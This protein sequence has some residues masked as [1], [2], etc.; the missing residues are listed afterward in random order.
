MSDLK[1]CKNCVH[2]VQVDKD[3]GQCY[4]PSTLSA[5]YF[6]I[7]NVLCCDCCDKFEGIKRRVVSTAKKQNVR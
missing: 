1:V 2:Y 4:Q 7:E 3:G 6:G 5:I